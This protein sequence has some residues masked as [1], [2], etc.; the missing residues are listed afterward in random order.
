[1]REGKKEGRDGDKRGRRI[2]KKGK[3]QWVRKRER[4]YAGRIQKAK[5]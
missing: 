1:M 4:E 5:R 2:G 3:R